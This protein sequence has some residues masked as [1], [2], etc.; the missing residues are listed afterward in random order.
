[1][2]RLTLRH[3]ISTGYIPTT[4]KG[5]VQC[6]EAE[7]LINSPSHLV[8]TLEKSLNTNHTNIQCDT[9]SEDDSFLEDVEMLKEYDNIRDAENVDPLN[10]YNENAITYFAGYIARRSV[11]KTK[12]DN[13]RNCMMKTPMDSAAENE[14]YI[15][16]REY[17]NADE[18]AP[19]VTKL[20]R[21]KDIFI[22]V[23]QTQLEVF[24]RTWQYYWAS[25]QILDKITNECVN[26]TNEKHLG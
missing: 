3:I 4:D 24:N 22:K 26:V 5:N 10:I 9:N 21:P 17:P 11:A 12:C 1:M 16:F 2:V 8:K 23:V 15:E 20:V 7:S 18:D 13:C 25:K 14:M 19:T 6:I